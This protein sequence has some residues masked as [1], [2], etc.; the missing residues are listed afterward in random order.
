MKCSRRHCQLPAHAT[1][2]RRF[3]PYGVF[4]LTEFT[5]ETV[6]FYSNLL[7]S[8]TSTSILLKENFCQQRMSYRIKF[9]VRTIYDAEDDTYYDFRTNTP[10]EHGTCTVDKN[11]GEAVLD[12]F[13][14]MCRDWV[15]VDLPLKYQLNIPRPDHH[16]VVSAA[17]NDNT[18][19]TRL[20]VGDKDDY[21]NLRIEVVVFDS[22]LATTKVNVTVIV[23]V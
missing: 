10:P 20:P 14:V 2:H 4:F 18:I 23:S 6:G 11:T 17:N 16:Y 12:E 15:D 5:N 22:L 21:Y 19:T 1:P 9:R 8:Y 13:R 7:T 3:T